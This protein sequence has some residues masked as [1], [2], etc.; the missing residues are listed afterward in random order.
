MARATKKKDERKEGE[1]RR[2]SF[3]LSTAGAVSL[4]VVTVAALAWVFILGVLVGRGYKPE[5]DVPEL[6]RIMPKA[7]ASAQQNKEGVLK[8]EELE[9]FDKLKQAPAGQESKSKTASPAKKSSPATAKKANKPAPQSATM[10]VAKTAA[11]SASAK[12]FAYRYQAA[13]IRDA[14]KAQ[15]FATRVISLGY[16]A[17]VEKA[18]TSSGVWH[19]VIVHFKG[20]PDQTRKLKEDLATLGVS[21]PIMKN[22]KPL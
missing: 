16:Q 5:R 10:S 11:P 3:S 4:G 19:R 22:K 9:F 15:Q 17:R 14:S 21:K 7:Q 6:E 1:P 18:T 20:T 13:A 2:F 12:R 8:P